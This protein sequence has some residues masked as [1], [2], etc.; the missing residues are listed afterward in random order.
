MP[1]AGEQAYHDQKSASQ[2]QHAGQAKQRNQ[3]DAIEHRDM[4]YAE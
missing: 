3:L 1:L 4:R 2:L